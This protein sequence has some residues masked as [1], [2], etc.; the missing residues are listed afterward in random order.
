MTTTRKISRIIAVFSL[1]LCFAGCQV[2]APPPIPTP[3]VPVP[4]AAERASAV[5]FYLDTTVT[6]SAYG[7]TKQELDE[8]LAQCAVYEALLSKTIQGSDVYTLNHANGAPVEVSDHTRILLEKALSISALSN[9]AF[10]ITIAPATELW[11]FKSA[12]PTLPDAAVLQAA[13]ALV[14]YQNI[15]LSGNTVT[16]PAGM[17][18]DLGGI[19]KGY[20]A[21][22][23]A[24][25]CRA[26]GI[27]SGMLNFGGNVVVIGAK[28]DGS[29]WNVGIQDPDESTGAFLAAIPAVNSSVV[30]SGTYERGFD[31]DG[32]RYHHILDTRTGW[33]IQNGLTSVTILAQ[34]SMEADALSTA[35][36]ALGI[37]GGMA[38]LR[39]NFPE[40]NAVFITTDRKITATEGAAQLLTLK[41]QE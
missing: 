29:P 10:D 19:A 4:P 34:S 17:M 18:I 41:A 32:V 20:I 22:E 25:I 37:E 2:A 21:D 23:I 5:G 38:L 39:D 26:R 33:P 28:Q 1:L 31:L 14:G 16:L 3:A 7:A 11:D 8:I 36:F 6:I 27:T 13:A 30:T 15:S 35:C 9:G 12:P 40:I 24:D